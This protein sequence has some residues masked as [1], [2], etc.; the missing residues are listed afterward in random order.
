MPRKKKRRHK[1]REQK[2]LDRAHW[3]SEDLILEAGWVTNAAEELLQTLYEHS[4]P[5]RRQVA[6][7]L[8]QLEVLILNLLKANQDRDGLM[9]V[10][11]RPAGYGD[12]LTF[13]VTKQH[14][15]DTLI[16]MG[17]LD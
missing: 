13:R 4:K 17:W 7:H 14:H 6:K 2:A 11:F 1:S 8:P 10:P 9:I 15:I 12:T 5:V 3:L 16:E